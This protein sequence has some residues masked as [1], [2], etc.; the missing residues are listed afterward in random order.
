MS[1]ITEPDLPEDY[2]EAHTA[3]LTKL[4]SKLVLRE[5]L[6]NIY[7]INLALNA[8]VLERL[9]VRDV[10]ENINDTINTVS[11]LQIISE[12][13]PLIISKDVYNKNYVLMVDKAKYRKFIIEKLLKQKR[14]L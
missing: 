9:V 7:K 13:Y 6:T 1:I 2:A 8:I 5:E 10:K 4:Y 14:G 12:E 11:I 3:V